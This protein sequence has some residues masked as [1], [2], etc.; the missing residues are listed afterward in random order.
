MFA[1]VGDKRKGANDRKLLQNKEYLRKKISVRI[2]DCLRTA[3]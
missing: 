1:W 2:L 3:E